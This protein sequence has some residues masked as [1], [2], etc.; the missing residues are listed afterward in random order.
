VIAYL[1]GQFADSEA[2]TISPL[3]RGFLF[4]DSVYEVLPVYQGA[5]FRSKGHLRRLSH[6][7]NSVSI[8]NPY[9]ESQWRAIFAE[10]I[11]RSGLS[12]LSIYLQVSRGAAHTREH[13]PAEQLTA[14]VFA[15]AMPA[16]EMPAEIFE[17]GVAITLVDDIR[18]ARCDIK[19][20]NLLA[21]VLYAL[22]LKERAFYEAVMVRDG[23]LSEATTSNVFIVRDGCLWTPPLSTTVLAGITREV[24]IEIAQQRAIPCHEVALK[25]QALRTADEL[26]LSSSTRTI[27][28]VTRIDE[29]PIGDGLPGKLWLSFSNTLRRWAAAE[30]AA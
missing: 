20:T 16:R 6:S 15:M 22:Q 7:L 26:W 18:W 27:V 13:L 12:D 19:S 17:K 29:Q 28:P 14:T 24:V 2:C 3:D 4:G 9:S 1:N 30:R 5:I 10:L 21:S 23:F 11:R 8:A 25:P